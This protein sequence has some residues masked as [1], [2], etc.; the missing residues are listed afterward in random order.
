[1]GISEIW[2]YQAENIVKQP[3]S[4]ECPGCEK[5]KREGAAFC[6]ICGRSL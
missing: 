3:E 2:N 4:N 1:M 5:K 6:N